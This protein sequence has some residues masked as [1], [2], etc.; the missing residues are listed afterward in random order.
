MLKPGPKCFGVFACLEAFYHINLTHQQHYRSFEAN[1]ISQYL[2]STNI[3]T[4]HVCHTFW[5]FKLLLCIIQFHGSWRHPRDKNSLFLC[6][7]P[8]VQHVLHGIFHGKSPLFSGQGAPQLWKKI[9][10]IYDC[11]VISHYIVI[12]DNIDKQPKC[13][14]CKSY[15][16]LLFSAPIS[17]KYGVVPCKS[18]TIQT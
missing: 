12:T 14:N 15:S 3:I 2:T 18:K 11:C 8:L 1:W 16:M 13:I 6:L 17:T 4:H 5:Y 10:D 7:S 9:F